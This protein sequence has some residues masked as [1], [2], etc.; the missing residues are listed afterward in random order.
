MQ[1]RIKA[2]WGPVQSPFWGPCFEIF[3]DRGWEGGWRLT[4][5]E[6][7]K[8]GVF[9]YNSC[10][11]W[12]ET[13]PLYSHGPVQPVPLVPPLIRHWSDGIKALLWDDAIRIRNKRN[14]QCALDGNKKGSIYTH[15]LNSFQNQI[16]DVSAQLFGRYFNFQN[17]ATKQFLHANNDD[18]SGHR[19]LDHKK[20]I[21]EL[22]PI[23]NGKYFVFR[24]YAT[25]WTLDSNYRESSTKK[26]L[27]SGVRTYHDYTGTDG[28]QHWII[29]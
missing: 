15:V 29:Y 19:D 3:S 25:G 11:I 6:T 27:C 2:C 20:G 12:P 1:C 8:C 7:I 5:P 14:F 24:N 10:N 21:W 9:E 16:W 17:R 4:L 26:D 13:G 23:E 28:Y 18:V 22:R